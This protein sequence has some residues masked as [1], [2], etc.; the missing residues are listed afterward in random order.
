MKYSE[1]RAYDAPNVKVFN[2]DNSNIICTSGEG[3][4]SEDFENGGEV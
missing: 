1:K 3:G 4:A 2:V